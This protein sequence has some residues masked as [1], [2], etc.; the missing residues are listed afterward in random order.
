MVLE[1]DRVQTRLMQK[2]ERS[3]EFTAKCLI[4]ALEGS[5]RTYAALNKKLPLKAPQMEVE[6]RMINQAYETLKGLHSAIQLTTVGRSYM[7]GDLIPVQKGS[8]PD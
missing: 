7:Y 2:A 8:S 5:V 4:D 6:A 1:R 3:R